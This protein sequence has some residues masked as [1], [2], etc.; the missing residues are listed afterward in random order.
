MFHF[1]KRL[2]QTDFK[3]LKKLLKNIFSKG[4]KKF[5]N[6]SFFLNFFG[7]KPWKTKIEIPM[8]AWCGGWKI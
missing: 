8:R 3:K 1:S 6:N 5:S 2:A 4:E 7:Q